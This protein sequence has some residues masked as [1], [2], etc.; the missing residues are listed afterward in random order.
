MTRLLPFL[1][2]HRPP[3]LPANWSSQVFLINRSATV[4]LRSISTIHVKQQHN[5]G[6][7]IFKFT[8]KYMQGIITYMLAMFIYNK[9][10]L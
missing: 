8:L 6:F 9:F 1:K 3:T 7:L 10:T 5:V 2:I 4:K